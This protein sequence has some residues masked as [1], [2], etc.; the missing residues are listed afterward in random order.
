MSTT[1]PQIGD[2]AHMTDRPIDPEAH[3]T[4]L[5][6]LQDADPADAPGI[7]EDLA[8]RLASELDGTTSTPDPAQEVPS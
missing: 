7:A 4:D 1:T 6:T 8:D 2:N 3:D 5:Q